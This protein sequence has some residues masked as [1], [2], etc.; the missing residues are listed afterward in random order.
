MTLKSRSAKGRS[1]GGSVHGMTAGLAPAGTDA[2]TGSKHDAGA[3]GD[4]GI[5]SDAG[6]AAKPRPATFA[7]GVKYAAGNSPAAVTTATLDGHTDI[8]VADV[9][10]GVSVLLG[11]GAG[12]FGAPTSF[13]A[14]L[15]PF[16]LA[17]SDV[18]HDGNTDLV[19]ADY[20]GGVS[21]LL[22]DGRGGFAAPITLA[23]GS[24]PYAVTTADLN[25]RGKTDIIVANFKGANVSVLLGYGSKFAPAVNYAAGVGPDALATA[26]FNGDGKLDLAVAD[27]NG[28]VSVLLG[29]GTGRFGAAT[30][31]AAGM[32]PTG[33]AVADL[34]GDGKADLIVSDRFNAVSVLLNNGTGGF[35]PATTYA[36]GS[37][38]V[39]VALADLNGDGFVDIVVADQGAGI[40]V[41]LNDG[42]GGFGRATSFAAG[43]SPASVTIADVNGDGR[44]D[45]IVADSGGGVTVLLNTTAGTFKTTEAIAHTAC[46]V[47][48]TAIATTRGSV[49]VQDLR[50]GDLAKTPRGD[51][52]I[53][54]IGRRRIGLATHPRPEYVRPIRFAVGSLGDNL[55]CRPLLLS[56]DHALFLAGVLVAAR[57]LVNG[58][59][60]SVDHVADVEYFHVETARHT[61]L[62]AEGVPAESYLDTGNRAQFE[63]AG[64]VMTLHA[65][66]DR[67]DSADAFAPLVTDAAIVRPIWERL[68]ARAGRSATHTPAVTR[69]PCLRLALRD[70]RVLTPARVEANGRHV[71]KLTDANGRAYGS[72]TARLRSRRAAPADIRPWLDDRRQLGV[73][74]ASITTWTAPG[75]LAPHAVA[76]DTLP[77]GA[78]WWTADHAD[79]GSRWTDGNAAIDLPAGCRRLVVAVDATAEYRARDTVSRR[80]A[81]V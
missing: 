67:A 12:G 71:F 58:V 74:V 3:T 51:E 38:P 68:A 73:A 41:L 50:V 45:I 11:N 57:Q 80:L 14:G 64:S 36:T 55:P 4:V 61:I 16:A 79:G 17:T 19:V 62:F 69:D 24:E 77:S 28:G 6:A 75:G 72:G 43:S 35:N 8:I 81:L 65:E 53:V 78:G 22:G 34:N 5:A 2:T 25:G 56:P 15:G 37:E 40:S 46:F 33:V 18:N 60:I 7:T 47:R 27:F 52:P 30:S 1:A 29:T 63:N 23:A 20:R 26:D 13:N 44:P 31:Y 59:S 39:S 66:F 70:G 42:H 21:V 49:A 32:E 76:L 10:G 48:D 54:W 9:Y